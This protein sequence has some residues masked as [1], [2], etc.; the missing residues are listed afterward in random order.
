MTIISNHTQVQERGTLPWPGAALFDTF[1]PDLRGDVFVFKERP[2]GLDSMYCTV[3]DL[4]HL[5]VQV[6]HT[7]IPVPQYI[8]MTQV[9]Y[10]Y[11]SIDLDENG[12][13]TWHTHDSCEGGKILKK[14]TQQAL[15]TVLVRI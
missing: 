11:S 15:P 12:V 14:P 6:W 1:Q 3:R 10:W 8:P 4:Y 5:Q 9:Q 13:D 7:C 2:Q